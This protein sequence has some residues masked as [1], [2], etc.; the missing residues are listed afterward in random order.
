MNGRETGPR[1]VAHMIGSLHTGGAERALINVLLAAD[2]KDFRYTVICLGYRGELAP[3]LEAAGIPVHVMRIRH[4]HLL[5]SIPR[6]ARWLRRENVVVVHAHMY[7]AGLWGRLAGRLAGVPV[8]MTTEHGPDLWKGPQH[9]AFDRLLTRWTA[10]HIAVAQDGLEL[11]LRR[12]RV[13]PDRIVLIPNGV[14]IPAVC[15]DPNRSRLARQEFGLAPDTPVI[16]SVGRLVPEKGYVH[17]LEA[18]KLARVELPG[19]RWLA[20]GDGP[21]RQELAAR[22][23]EMGLDD[24]VIWAGLRTDIDLLLEA[25]DLWVMSSV[26]EGLPVALLEAMAA[27]CPIVATQVGGIPEAV[28][29]GREA[30]LVP[31]LDPAALAGAIVELLRNPARARELGHA[32]RARAE[33]QYSI[34]SVVRK[35]EDIYREELARAPRGPAGR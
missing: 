32:A 5:V 31:S 9:I 19:L 22:T 12:E 15:R 24:A 16:G 14:A 7:W 28:S 10:R 34:G 17:M 18:L 20:I 21:L 30:M 13:R 6:L 35:V 25:M 4:R 26:S 8:L 3:V 27:A 11:R 23:T 33:A 2:R 29:D 1:H